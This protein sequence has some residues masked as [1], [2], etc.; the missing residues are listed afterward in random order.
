VIPVSAT[1]WPQLSSLLDQALDLPADERAAWLE[2]LRRQQPSLQPVIQQ[3]LAA[4]AKHETGD[5]LNQGP[6]LLVQAYGPAARDESAEQLQV[7]DA[8]GPYRLLRALGSGGMAVVWLAERSDGQLTRQVALKL[9]QRFVWRPGLA[10]RFGREGDILARLEHT[11]IARLYD[12]GVC[13]VDGPGAGRPYLVL[14]YVEGAHLTAYCDEHKLDTAQ[15]LALLMQVL[16]AV[17][18]AHTRLVIHRDLKPANILVNPGGDV[19][20]LDF[21]VAKLLADADD[22]GVSSELTQ[23]VGR[24]FTPDY[25]SPEQVR[26]EA[27][28]TTSDVYSLGVV[29]YEL[30]CGQ[31]PY[32]LSHS[33]PAQLEQAIIEVDPAPPSS[34][35]TE[36]AAAARGCTLHA[37]RRSLRGEL[38]TIVLKAL[39]KRP[40]QR[41]STVTE[42]AEDLRRHRDGQPVL[43]RP[44]SRLYRARK[45][46]LRNRLAVG[47]VVLVTLA[48]L[49]GSAMS[50][51]QASVAKRQ[52]QRARAIQAFMAD[53]FRT[54]TDAQAD[55][56]KARQTTARELLDI[57]AKR[58]DSNLQDDPEGRAEVL[59]LLGDMYY[60]LGLDEQAADLYGRRVAALKAA[61]GAGDRRVAQALAG[62]GQQ[63]EGLGDRGEEQRRV[64]DEAKA[65]LDRLGDTHS[66]QRAELLWAMAT[67]YSHSGQQAI[68]HARQSVA[69]YR[70]HHP[71]SPDFANALNRLG[72]SLWRVDDLAGAEAAFIETLALL[73][74]DTQ[75]SVSTQMTALLTLANAQN[76]LQKVPAAE[77]S[78]RRALALTL[79]RNGAAH[80]DTLHSQSAF[81]LFLLRTS[82]REE[83][84]QLLRSAEAMVAQNTYPPYP[85]TVV[86]SSVAQALL[87]EGRWD[88]A[89]SRLESVID[90]YRKVASGKSPL[91]VAALRLRAE[92]RLGQGRLD[93]AERALAEAMSLL[94]RL[95]PAQQRTVSNPVALVAARIALHRQ[96]PDIALQALARV[97]PRRGA[98][99]NPLPVD[100]TLGQALRAL[101]LLQQGLNAQ[102]RDTAEALLGRMRASPLRAYYRPIEADAQEALGRVMLSEGRMD[103]ACRAFDEAV[104]LRLAAFGEGSGH[105]LAAQRASADCPRGRSG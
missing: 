74:S 8:I 62:Y 80:V 71:K 78:H 72:I 92:Q 57:G 103:D 11:H 61:F 35:I 105:V 27:L 60:G 18:Y 77:A 44:E 69:I 96:Q 43:A 53:I 25:A 41:Y 54:N 26:G 93:G 81:G 1:L 97:A 65:I 19:K 101:A 67:A 46:V 37:L 49:I 98:E 99:N 75:A 58:I 45:F 5:F 33:S 82:R 4:H 29:L 73:E 7:G 12:A 22:P 63:L 40:E 88:D 86:R 34:R 89:E 28:G 95:S 52:A 55:P 16:E 59:L 87:F 38:D 3:L 24:L 23:Q 30:L 70:Q 2:D 66:E 21:G 36:E 90:Y 56:L 13:A 6:T 39:H 17:Q 50:L 31:R 9:P 10:E 51:W 85:E 64:L 14:E 15:R 68:D 48:L 102:A 91:L 94:A 83:A 42:L 100:L 32:R 20:L 104:A 76:L 47:A 84:W 79:E